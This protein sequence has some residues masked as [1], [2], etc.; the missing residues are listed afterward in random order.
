ML[1]W[2][3]SGRPE[4]VDAR[5]ELLL[6]ALLG[7]DRLPC[8]RTLRRSLARFSAHTI[9]A[10]VEVAYLVELSHRTGR[11]RVALDAH[12]VPYWGRGKRERFAKGWSGSHGRSLQGYRLYLAVDTDTG[13][14]ITYALAHGRTR[15]AQMSALLARRVRRL[16]GRRLAGAVA[17]CGFTSRAA[18]AALIATNVPFM[19]GFAR[20]KPVRARLD[21]LS[22]HE[23]RW[24][25]DGGAI[26]LGACHWDTRLRLIALAA[27]TPTDQRVPWGSVTRL[28]GPGPQAL[29]RLYRQR[30]RV[31]QA[32][33]ELLHG[34]DLDHLVGYRLHPNRVAIGSLCGLSWEHLRRVGVLGRENDVRATNL[35]VPLF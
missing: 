10:V 14:V 24:L 27:R 23:R 30:W 31:E 17:D 13:Q 9:R 6:A 33:E 7:R 22:G 12:Q 1:A 32:I 34:H 2:R 26:D 35:I 21:R 3:G 4:H 15:D 8:A 5:D 19:L 29:A 16:L 25:R 11:V 18:V 20:F 28:W